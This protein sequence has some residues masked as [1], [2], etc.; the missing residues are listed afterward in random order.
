MLIRTLKA[1]TKCRC[2]FS[3]G[4][5]MP[6]V[7]PGGGVIGVYIACACSD[8]QAIH[9]DDHSHGLQQIELDKDGNLVTLA[10]GWNCFRCGKKQMVVNGAMVSCGH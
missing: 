3:P 5:A 7:A 8:V 10:P 9:P 6:V 4:E 2:E 1:W